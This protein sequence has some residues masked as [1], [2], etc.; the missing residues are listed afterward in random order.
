MYIL[1]MLANAGTKASPIRWLTFFTLFDARG[2]AAGDGAAGLSA[3]ILLAGAFLLFALGV[4]I[5][6]KKDLHI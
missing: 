2:L 1:Q 6:S 5:F 3:L 4:V